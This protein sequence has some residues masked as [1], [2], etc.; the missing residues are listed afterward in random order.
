MSDLIGT[1]LNFL[2]SLDLIGTIA[3][4]VQG[5]TKLEYSGSY[6]AALAHK[7]KLER[8]GVSCRIEGGGL[9]NA[10]VY[11]RPEEIGGER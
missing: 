3:N 11:T 1:A 5:Y 7:I 6:A 4:E 2:G 8:Q 9:T 10:C